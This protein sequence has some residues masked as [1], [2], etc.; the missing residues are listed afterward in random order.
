MNPKSRQ[1]G[2]R[3]LRQEDS[4]KEEAGEGG[5]GRVVGDVC[6]GEANCFLET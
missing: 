2:S 1:G 4:E 5:R 6:S 3:R